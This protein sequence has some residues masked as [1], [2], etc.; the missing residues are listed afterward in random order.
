MRAKCTVTR[1]VLFR[2]G[3][4]PAQAPPPTPP[5]PFLESQ[6]ESAC[7][8]CRGQGSEMNALGRRREAGLPLSRYGCTPRPRPRQARC[9]LKYTHGEGLSRQSSQLTQSLTTTFPEKKRVNIV[10][11]ILDGVRGTN[12]A[13]GRV[14]AH[15]RPRRGGPNQTTPLASGDWSWLLHH[16]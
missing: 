14:K 5:H 8:Q 11:Q 15:R 10:V 6:R 1:A 3:H 9:A 7:V 4:L 2:S 12:R 16:L 13:N